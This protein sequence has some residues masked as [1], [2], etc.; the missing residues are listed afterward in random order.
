MVNQCR[1]E[2]D[3]SVNWH[4]VIGGGIVGASAA[5]HLAR[6][7]HRTVLIDRRDHG[8]ATTAGAGIIAPGTSRRDIPPFYEMAVP[9][10]TYYP[11]LIRALDDV[12]AGDTPR[13][14]CRA[15]SF[16]PRVTRKRLSSR[17]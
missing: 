4:V 11:E 5:Y 17:I 15:S 10:V 6:D 7:G 2:R 8:R 16:S 14:P 9:A 13:T 12:D 1:A 3:G